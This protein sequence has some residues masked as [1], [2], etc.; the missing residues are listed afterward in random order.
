M[1]VDAAVHRARRHVH[2]VADAG[3]RGGGEHIAGALHS[4]RTQLAH[5]MRRLELPRQ[6]DNNIDPFERRSQL[7][8][9]IPATDVY[10]E[11]SGAVIRRHRPGNPSR[12]PDQV[13][14]GPGKLGQEC[15]AQVAAGSGDGDAH[16]AALPRAF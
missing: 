6:V 15:R 4:G 7:P 11:P 14:S 1:I 12:D 9:R 13:M 16:A 10:R 2:Q 8:D 3:G 5:S